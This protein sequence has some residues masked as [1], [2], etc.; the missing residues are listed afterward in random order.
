VTGDPEAPAVLRLD[1]L[2]FSYP[3]GTTALREVQFT[4]ERGEIIG[5]LGPNGCGKTTLLRV[6]AHAS[7]LPNPA[8][9]L[10]ES[11]SVALAL[12][13]PVF[14]G[15][16]SG[17]ENARTYLRLRGM[18]RPEAEGVATTW[19]DRFGLAEV[20][21]RTVSTYSRGTEH[22]LALALTFATHPGLILLDEPLTG[23]DPA[24]RDRFTR[25]LAESA[26]D[27]AAALLSTH[28]PDFAS[29]HCDRVAFLSDGQVLAIDRPASFL[30]AIV[31]MTRIEV[32]F[33]ASSLPL[34]AR[35]TP[36]SGIVERARSPRS[37][38]LETEDAASALP[39]ALEWLSLAGARV[40]GVDVREP[41]LRD[42]YFAV[43]G[44]RLDPEADA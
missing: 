36:P 33:T 12:D 34:D 28:D 13:R 22:R 27:G 11:D 6:I 1:R 32:R 43:T 38:S 30:S 41:G 17:R 40:T 5:L 24:A 20:A 4:V 3:D 25:I 19:I 26:A 42:A 39:R 9:S 8:I 44:R 18:T 10:P 15:W 23:L 35:S 14:R 16:L 29:S 2:G 7:G 37:I 21:E 31:G